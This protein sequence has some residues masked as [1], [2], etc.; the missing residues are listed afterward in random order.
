MP[1]IKT[2]ALTAELRVAAGT[3]SIF[4]SVAISRSVPSSSAMET[5]IDESL[6]P[7]QIAL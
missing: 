1:T 4:A 2:L 3:E 6:Y 5:F 7:A